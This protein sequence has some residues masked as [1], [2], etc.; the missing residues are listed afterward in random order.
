MKQ[1]LVALLCLVA[2]VLA[3]LSACNSAPPQLSQTEAM[4]GVNG[5]DNATAGAQ[6]AFLYYDQQ[7]ESALVQQVWSTIN[8][9]AGEEGV[10]CAPY[11][12]AADEGEPTLALALK[13][14]AKL[15]V[16]VGEET[17]ELLRQNQ[18]KNPDVNFVIVD[19]NGAV[20]LANNSLAVEYSAGQAGW[21]AGW[22]AVMDGYRSLLFLWDEDAAAQ[23]YAT[24]FLYGAQ[25]A[26]EDLGLGEEEKIRAAYIDL[27]QEDETPWQQRFEEYLAQ[28]ERCVVFSNVAEQAGEVLTLAR[29]HSAPVIELDG[30]DALPKNGVLTA[31]RRTAHDTLYKAMKSWKQGAVFG[32]KTMFA[33]GADGGVALEME[34]AAF[35]LFTPEDNEAMMQLFASGKLPGAALPVWGATEELESPWEQEW[36]WLVLIRLETP[37]EPPSSYNSSTQNTSKEPQEGGQPETPPTEEPEKGD[38]ASEPDSSSDEQNDSSAVNEAMTQPDAEATE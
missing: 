7:A 4:S 19:S 10:T 31:I 20:V 11:Q 21:M 28:Q 27:Q 32:G 8:Q 23:Q 16:L 22:A 38:A 30:A 37:P 6:I 18:R 36:A 35:T 5:A 15:V 2:T 17:A 14:G 3:V 13:G 9:F 25:A 12:M 29:K 1:R 34:G 33:G 26:A 24:G